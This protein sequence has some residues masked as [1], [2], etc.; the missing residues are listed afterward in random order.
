V[1]TLSNIISDI[2]LCR[3]PITPVHQID[4][5]SET[6]QTNYFTSRIIKTIN[7]CSYQARTATIKVNGYV[8]DEWLQNVNYGFY[9]NKYQDIEKKFY[10]FI[11]QKNYSAKGT[12]E[13]V[14]VIDAF[15]T[16]QFYFQFQPSMVERKHVTDDT[17]GYNTYPEGFEL[18]EYV[19]HNRIEVEY[20]KGD[21]AYCMAITPKGSEQGHIYGKQYSA[22]EYRIYY[23]SSYTQLANDINQIVSSGQGDSIAFIFTVPRAFFDYLSNGITLSGDDGIT[24]KTKNYNWSDATKDF[25]FNG[26]SWTPFNNKMYTYPYNFITIKDN[27]G[28][29]VVLKWELF[30]DINDVE[31]FIDSVFTHNPTF[32]ISPTNYCNRGLSIEDSLQTEGFGLCSW[33]NDNYASW[34]AQ[35]QNSITAQSVNA[36]ASY[37]ANSQVQNNDYSNALSQRDNNMYK[38]AIGTGLGT[39][40]NL[41]SGNVQGA[42]MGSIQGGANGYLDYQQSGRNADTT[43][44][45]SDILNRNNYQNAIRSTMASVQDAKV[46]PNTA[47]GDTSSTGLD[48][49]RDTVTF[50]IEQTTIKPEFAQKIDLYFQ[51]FGYQ[52]NSLEVPTLRTRDKWNYIKTVNAVITSNLNEKTIPLEDIRMLEDIFNNGVTIWHSESYMY[53]YAVQNNIL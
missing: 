42:I 20:M 4:F 5:T 35:H 40:G 33:N 52:V 37:N 34:Y 12:T 7:N 1:K 17:I 49:A 41:I 18:G 44:I 43:W 15:Q 38:G 21:V 53:Q 16:W 39:V 2:Y 51:M 3:V 50:F 22:F 24:R 31:F 23:Q 13:L 27:K 30:N 45:N 9:V 14:I 36:I 10:F 6:E 11:A 25:N 19:S 46:Q 26:R 47:K 28:S 48:L 29:N 32:T 8:D